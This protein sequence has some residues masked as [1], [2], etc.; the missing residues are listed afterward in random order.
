MVK[1]SLQA[2]PSFWPKLLINSY[3]GLESVKI[4]TLTFILR[5]LDI[6]LDRL[7]LSSTTFIKAV[8][9]AAFRYI[10]NILI[11]RDFLYNG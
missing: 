2:F 10:H 9:S 11:T 4:L 3:N 5:S 6:C 1:D 8:V 7:V